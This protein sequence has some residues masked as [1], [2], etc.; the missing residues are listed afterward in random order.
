MELVFFLRGRSWI[1]QFCSHN[2]NFRSNYVAIRSTTVMLRNKIQAQC[3]N[4]LKYKF[5]GSII[6]WGPVGSLVANHYYIDPA[7]WTQTSAQVLWHWTVTNNW[8]K[9]CT[10][11]Q[12][13]N[14]HGHNIKLDQNKRLSDLLEFWEKCRTLLWLSELWLACTSPQLK[15][16][17]A[18][19]LNYVHSANQAFFLKRHTSLA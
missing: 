14:M 16:I 10:S 7:G 5:M 18:K 12:K 13:K 17:A 2:T 11:V 3:I 4:W 19:T 9:N 6:F 1:T 8:A 15:K